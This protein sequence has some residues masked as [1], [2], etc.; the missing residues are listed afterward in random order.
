[1]TVNTLQWYVVHT[2]PRQEARA[3]RSL[4]RLQIEWLSPRISQDKLIRGR[5]RSVIG[6]LFPGYLFARFEIDTH[7]RAVTYAQGVQ[8][9]VAFGLRPVPVDDEIIGAIRS[10]LIDNCVVVGGRALTPGQA[11]RIQYGPLQGLEAVFEQEL[12]DR[13]RAVVLLR[14]LSYQARVVVDVASVAAV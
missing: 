13:E 11:V 4:D 7:Y 9:L 2:K 12:S 14:A 6:P 10:R 1:M 3:E 5:R 8:Q